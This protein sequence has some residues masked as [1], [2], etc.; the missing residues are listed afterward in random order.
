MPNP[1]YQEAAFAILLLTAT[2]RNVLLIRRLPRGHPARS[3]ITRMIGTGIIVFAASFA[4]W[5]IDNI[6]CQSLRRARQYMGIWGIVLEGEYF[7]DLEQ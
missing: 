2:G 4:I 5:N 7:D 6:F 3:A 1:I